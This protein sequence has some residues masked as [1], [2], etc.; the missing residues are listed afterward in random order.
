M[1]R[2]IEQ[3]YNDLW[4]IMTYLDEIGY[5]YNK[6]NAQLTWEERVLI[7]GK[8]E[9]VATPPPMSEQELRVGY[10]LWHILTSFLK[11]FGRG[12]NMPETISENAYCMF[13]AP[14]ATRVSK[15]K[16]SKCSWD[17]IHQGKRIQI[18]STTIDDD[19]TSFG[20]KSE[21]DA[22]VFEEFD[23]L[24]NKVSF[25]DL[26]NDKSFDN[27]QINKKQTFKNQ[28]Q[29]GKRPRFSIKKKIIVPGKITPRGTYDILK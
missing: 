16:N 23:L 13:H 10:V 14:G 12:I 8:K 3:I 20:P 21:W 26:G 19:L 1:T 29:Q 25:Y 22:L 17:C 9:H 4:S 27:I 18:K 15:I 2:T 11:R 28:K 24:N 7:N 5:G 6:N